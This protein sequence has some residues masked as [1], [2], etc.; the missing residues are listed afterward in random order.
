M[1]IAECLLLDV[2]CTCDQ[3]QTFNISTA[4]VIHVLNVSTVLNVLNMSNVSDSSDGLT[5]GCMAGWLAD[6]VGTGVSQLCNV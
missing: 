2:G 4:L 1:L 5:A 6:W 3:H